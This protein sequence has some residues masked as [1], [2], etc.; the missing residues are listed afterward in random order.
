MDMPVQSIIH[1]RSGLTHVVEF[2]IS[3]LN[4]GVLMK[5]ET[6]RQKVLLVNFFGVAS[7]FKHIISVIN[8]FQTHYALF[9]VGIEMRIRHAGHSVKGLQK[10]E[11]SIKPL[12]L[13]IQ[14]YRIDDADGV[15]DGNGHEQDDYQR[16]QNNFEC[17]ESFLHG[18][19][20]YENLSYE[21]CGT[22]SE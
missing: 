10:F 7:L 18:D 19:Y 1:C 15:G 12:R 11:L 22:S 14:L 9:V 3:Q 5:G 20:L 13:I 4:I 21:D 17:G 16:A 2:Y 6:A 8:D